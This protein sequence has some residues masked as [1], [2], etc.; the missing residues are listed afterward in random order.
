MYNNSHICMHTIKQKTPFHR[1]QAQDSRDYKCF[2][3]TQRSQKLCQLC[4]GLGTCTEG[5]E[6]AEQVT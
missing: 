1:S 3:I 5:G 6:V 4:R 2:L